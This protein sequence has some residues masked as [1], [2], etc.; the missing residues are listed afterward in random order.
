MLDIVTLTGL[1]WVYDKVE[2]RHGRAAAWVATITL[3]VALLAALV[4]VLVAIF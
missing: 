2:E 4:A 1:E 3:A